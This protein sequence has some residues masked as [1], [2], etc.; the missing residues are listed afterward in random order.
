MSLLEA[1]YG[2]VDRCGAWP[3]IPVVLKDGAKRPAIKTGVDHADGATVDLD[4][5]REWHR[6]GLLKA[7]GTPT[8]AVSGTV[9]IDVDLYKPGVAQVL[10]DLEDPEVL[11]PLPRSNVAQTPRGG[12]HI[13]CAHPG[14][15]VRVRCGG[16]K[17]PLSK[18]AGRPGVDIR[19][20]GG[21]VALPPSFGYSWIADE[22]G[23][24]EPLPAR[25]LFAI[26]GAGEP[27]RPKMI[28]IDTAISD[29]RKVPRARAYLAKM[30]PSIDGQGG[31]DALWA[32]VLAMR[33]GFDLDEATVRSIIANDFNPRCDPPW[34]ERDIDHKLDGVERS[35]K[36]SERGY[37]LR[38]AS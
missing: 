10:A 21:F 4:V 1:A 8:G 6:R 3:I 17:G 35:D 37:L 2:Y 24:L 31:H 9:V 23:Y 29:D 5:M 15:G 11:G 25:W 36:A 14:N 16:P 30:E 12:Q 19:G 32:A 7:I 20:D 27:S 22:D 18:L 34:D 26:N 38:S 28:A 33:I 13:Y